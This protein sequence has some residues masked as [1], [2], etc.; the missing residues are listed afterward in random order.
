[1]DA[2]FC[3][4]GGQNALSAK[5]NAEREEFEP[6]WRVSPPTA[7]P[8]RPSGVQGGALMG[9]AYSNSQRLGHHKAGEGTRVGSALGPFRVR[10]VCRVGTQSPH[11]S[12]R[13][14][15]QSRS[16]DRTLVCTIV[17]VL[18]PN[19]DVASK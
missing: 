4:V 16:G 3:N 1:M 6:S 15:K 5:G 8:D 12:E 18:E 2:I 13:E 10:L 7:L 11:S 9:T 14:A 19:L 17:L